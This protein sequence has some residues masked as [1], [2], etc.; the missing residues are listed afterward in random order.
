MC[1]TLKEKGVNRLSI[2]SSKE[3]LPVIFPFHA[4]YRGVI[5]RLGK[6]G[7]IPDVALVT[8][9]ILALGDQGAA[10]VAPLE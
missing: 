5:L 6:V 10:H 2:F 3:D 1:C 9:E 4:R 8:D 7:G